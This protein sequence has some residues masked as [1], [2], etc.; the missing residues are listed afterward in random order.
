MKK[1]IIAMLLAVA[2]MVSTVTIAS[3]EEVEDVHGGSLTIS[4]EVPVTYTLTI[5]ADMEI[6]YLDENEVIGTVVIDGNIKNSQEVVLTITPSD[7]DTY[8]N[9]MNVDDTTNK[10]PYRLENLWASDDNLCRSVTYSAE[11]VNEASRYVCSLVVRISADYWG[12]A[13]AAGTYS[14]TLTFATEIVDVVE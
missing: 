4:T 12:W 11:D 13:E 7:R 5:P 3:A 1:K 14:S 9:L 8:F 6:D 10:I 2:T